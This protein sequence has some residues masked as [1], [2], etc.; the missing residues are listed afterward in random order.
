[1]CTTA[2]IGIFWVR[3]G[4]DRLDVVP[5]GGVDA[6]LRQV[7]RRGARLHTVDDHCRAV[8]A[9]TPARRHVHCRPGQL[10]RQFRGGDRV[11]QHEGKSKLPYDFYNATR[12]DLIDPD[13]LALMP[14]QIFTTG[15]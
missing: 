10:D 1:M 3:A 11:S 15:V 12:I 14:A 8:L 7:L 13:T 2:L 4:N 9:R 6:L 5:V